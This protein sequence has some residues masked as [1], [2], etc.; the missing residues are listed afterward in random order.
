[1][2]GITMFNRLLFVKAGIMPGVSAWAGQAF[3]QASKQASKQK[4]WLRLELQASLD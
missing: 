1:M 2:K 4:G 3:Q